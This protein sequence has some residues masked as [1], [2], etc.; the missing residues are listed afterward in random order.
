MLSMASRPQL[1]TKNSGKLRY[2]ADTADL[3]K[4]VG[5]SQFDPVRPTALRRGQEKVPTLKVINCEIEAQIK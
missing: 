2:V 3:Q 5:A 4:V 1:Y